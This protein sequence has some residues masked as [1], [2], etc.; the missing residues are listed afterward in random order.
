MA[1]LKEMKELLLQA[2]EQG[3]EKLVADLAYK[4]GDTYR[5]KGKW[6]QAVPLLEESLELCRQHQNP[7]GEAVVAL[8]LAELHLEQSDPEPAQTLARRALEFYTEQQDIKGQ[9]KASLLVGDTYWA[10]KQHEAAI[11]HYEQALKPCKDHGDLAGTASLL[12]RLA[13]MH[14]LIDR[15]AEALAYFQ[16]ALDCWQRLSIPDRQAMTLA[17]IGDIC[18]RRGELPRAIRCHEQALALFRHL[19]SPKAIQALEKEL[20]TLRG[21]VEK[22]AAK[23][24]GR[25]SEID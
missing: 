8:S 25:E 20:E 4:I 15:E 16:E 18:K 6:D 7:E 5:E 23:G 3:E 12:D 24:E 14:R 1:S 22:V 21:M 17:N 13:K 11:P 19:K 2:R 10:M 9:V